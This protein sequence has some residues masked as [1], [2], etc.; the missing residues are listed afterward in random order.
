MPKLVRK[1]DLHAQELSFDAPCG[2][3]QEEA[4]AI[5]ERKPTIAVMTIQRVRRDAITHKKT[6]TEA[7]NPQVFRSLESFAAYLMDF[8]DSYEFHQEEAVDPTITGIFEQYVTEFNR[9][10][11]HYLSRLYISIEK[12]ADSPFANEDEVQE[13]EDRYS[14][15]EQLFSNDSCTVIDWEQWA[16][17][18]VLAE[19][20]G[21]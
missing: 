15:M 18:G 13:K 12:L 14:F 2:P 16:D 21:L 8:Y 7:M 10:C 20:F 19:V 6:I 1:K 11:F 9:A 3:L 5:V 4:A 17:S